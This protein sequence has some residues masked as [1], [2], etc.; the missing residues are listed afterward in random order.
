MPHSNTHALGCLLVVLAAAPILACGEESG[1][2]PSGAGAGAGDARPL[3][4]AEPGPGPD[5]FRDLGDE[6]GADAGP[7]AGA[8]EAEDA[9]GG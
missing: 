8:A 7:D 4:D 6:A 9:G 2:D 1:T 3:R 5:S